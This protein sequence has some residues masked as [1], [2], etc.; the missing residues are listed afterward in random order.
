MFEVQTPGTLID[1]WGL[2]KGAIQKSVE[3][4]KMVWRRLPEAKF[5][6]R[7]RNFFEDPHWKYKTSLRLASTEA[8]LGIT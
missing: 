1:L 7:V 6:F 4:E 2:I 5:V 8:L 3:V